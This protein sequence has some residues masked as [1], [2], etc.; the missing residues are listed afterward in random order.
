MYVQDL[1]TILHALAQQKARTATPRNRLDIGSAADVRATKA[2][3]F[4]P[5]FSD[6]CRAQVCLRRLYPHI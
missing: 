3:S 6:P 4:L 5:A 1:Y 2:K